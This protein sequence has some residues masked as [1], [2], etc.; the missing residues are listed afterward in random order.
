MAL[1]VVTDRDDVADRPCVF[2]LD[3]TAGE[4]AGAEV[5]GFAFDEMRECDRPG[6]RP[7]G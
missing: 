7:E 1:A 5:D 2:L 3:P 4:E 6:A